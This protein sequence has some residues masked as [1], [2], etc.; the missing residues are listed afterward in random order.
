MAT[1]P[2]GEITRGTTNPNRLRRVDNWIAATQGHV[3]RDAADPLVIDLG[4]GESPVTAVELRE[5]L[6]GAVRPDV[7]VVGLEIDPA[8]VAAAAPVADPP[9]LTFAR[10]GFE[11]AGLRP[12]VVRAFN[13][14]RQYDEPAVEGAW[15]TMSSALAPGGVLVEGTC[16]EVGRLASWVLLDA[17]GPRTLTLAAKL[18]ALDTPATLA[19]R[20][21]KALIHRNVPGEPI[22]A[23]VSALDDAWRDAAPY[24]TF[25]PRQRWLRTVSAVRAAGW[26]ILD[27][28]ARWRLGEVT[29]RWQTVAPSY[30][31]SG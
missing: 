3:L 21:P 10:G 24:A 31:T 30:L 2:Q 19:E 17:G 27:G 26:S 22:H 13:V 6:A 15:R 20:L 4:Y 5:R 1:R 11:L 7:R 25:G 8:R 23:F 28:P 16:D 18:S 29:V 9:R 14:L 12:A